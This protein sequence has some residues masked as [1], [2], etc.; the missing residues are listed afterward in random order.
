MFTKK[1]IGIISLIV[2]SFVIGGLAFNAY[3][4][5]A[6]G[7]GHMFNFSRGGCDLS[8]LERGSPE[9]QAKME[10]RKAQMEE[11]KVMTPEERQAK[12]EELKT[13]RTEN[14]EWKGRGLGLGIFDLKGFKGLSDELNYEVINIT[15]GVQITITSDNSDIVT[16]LQESAARLNDL[17]K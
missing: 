11:F 10:E 7:G 16:K 5:S 17:N 15:N 6:F 4:A 8:G 3:R 13:N 9:W 12:L 2:A 1:K 14:G